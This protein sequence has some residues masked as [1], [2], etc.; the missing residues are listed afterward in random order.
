MGRKRRTSKSALRQIQFT[1]P[2]ACK[3][4]CFKADGCKLDLGPEADCRELAYIYAGRLTLPLI[5]NKIVIDYFL[6]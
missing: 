5:A 4:V 1:Y 6:L 3:I 2:L